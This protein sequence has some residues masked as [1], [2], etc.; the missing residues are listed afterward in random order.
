MQ[1][2]KEIGLTIQNMLKHLILQILS[3]IGCNTKRQQN[4]VLKSIHSTANK[5]LL[6]SRKLW[7][8]SKN[9]KSKKSFTLKYSFL[10]MTTST[11][12]ER[13]GEVL[14]LKAEAFSLRKLNKIYIISFISE[15]K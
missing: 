10:L 13:D 12:T 14:M 15:N 9:S 6:C 7:V 8:K 3:V 2:I 5:C 1:Y 4:S 11:V